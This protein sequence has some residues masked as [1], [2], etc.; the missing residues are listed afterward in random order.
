[1]FVEFR[2]FMLKYVKAG[3]MHGGIQGL[4]SQAVLHSYTLRLSCGQLLVASSYSFH[5]GHEAC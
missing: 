2:L 5:N 4:P 3:E 1:M